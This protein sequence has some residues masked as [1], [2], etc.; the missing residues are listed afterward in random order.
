VPV[1]AVRRPRAAAGRARKLIADAREVTRCRRATN[2]TSRALRD[3]RKRAELL[4]SR[5]PPLRVGRVTLL[6]DDP[7]KVGAEDQGL[8][9]S[10]VLE[11]AR[12]RDVLGH[13][14]C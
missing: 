8:E 2:R 1:V 6:V 7:A 12:G 11:R 14:S 3:E 4:A 9:A 13:E 5:P 10:N